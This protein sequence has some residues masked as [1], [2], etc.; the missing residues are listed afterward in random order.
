LAEGSLK[1][2]LGTNYFI[3]CA[4]ILSHKGRSVLSV[5]ANPV[6][7][8]LEI[9][10]DAAAKTDKPEIKEVSREGYSGV[11]T[12]ED[13]AVAIATLLTPDVIHL[14]LD[15]RPLGMNI[16]DDPSGLHVGRNVFSG[17]VIEGAA[18]AINLA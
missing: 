2:I 1:V 4:S 17:N 12:K 7:I 10:P 18:A 11:F 16:F 15:L 9:P 14:K 8:E 3:D 13:Q 6:R 5:E